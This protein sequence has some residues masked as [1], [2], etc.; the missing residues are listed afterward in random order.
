MSFGKMIFFSK[1]AKEKVK[2]MSEHELTL[3]SLCLA[4]NLRESAFKIQKE[5]ESKNESDPNRKN[6][7]D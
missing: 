4:D 2:Q 6:S 7:S 1:E 5:L 3:L